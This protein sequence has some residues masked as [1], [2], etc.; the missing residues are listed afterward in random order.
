MMAMGDTLEEN[1]TS[2][3]TPRL[4]KVVGAVAGGL[5][6][7]ALSRGGSIKRRLIFVAT[8]AALGAV[9]GRFWDARRT[10]TADE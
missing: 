10:S 5:C 3:R 2:A 7:Y 1:E 6:G 9:A 8:G 4:G